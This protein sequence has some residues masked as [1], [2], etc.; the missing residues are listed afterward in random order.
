MTFNPNNH[1]GLTMFYSNYSADKNFDLNASAKAGNYADYFAA[2][3][4]SVDY[5]VNK[6]VTDKGVPFKN[7][8]HEANYRAKAYRNAF[9]TYADLHSTYVEKGV[10]VR[11]DPAVFGFN[12]S[13]VDPRA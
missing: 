2:T 8:E 7:T 12:G 9:K 13:R 1:K 10:T 6:G 4:A 5:Y 11:K 3:K